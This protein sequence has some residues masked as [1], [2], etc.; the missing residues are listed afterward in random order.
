VSGVCPSSAS[1]IRTK[2]A[3]QSTSSAID[4]EPSGSFVKASIARSTAG[5]LC[6]GPSPIAANV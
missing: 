3:T 1:S 5:A 2:R 6:G 4:T